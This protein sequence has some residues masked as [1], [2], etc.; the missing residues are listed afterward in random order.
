LVCLQRAIFSSDCHYIW[1]LILRLTLQWT[2]SPPSTLLQDNV[3]VWQLTI[4][5]SVL[6]G[7]LFM[8]LERHCGVL[9]AERKLLWLCFIFLPYILIG[10][11]KRKSRMRFVR[12]V[13]CVPVSGLCVK[14]LNW[15]RDLYNVFKLFFY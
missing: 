13:R 5:H 10:I 1:F 15:L 4:L 8:P 9:E 7:L 12:H 11:S 2:V 14:H 6:A 3:N